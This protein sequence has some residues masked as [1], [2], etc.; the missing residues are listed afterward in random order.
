MDT[1]HQ[2]D[3]VDEATGKLTKGVYHINL[4]DEVTQWEVV[5]AVETISEHFLKPALEL[6]LECFPFVLHNF[7][8]DNGS[9][10]INGMVE[11]LL[12]ELN[13]AQTKSRARKSTDNGLVESKNGS[14]LR[15]EL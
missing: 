6:A 3:L 10:F 5:I 7:H 4:V 8:S 12:R 2:G 9:E 13:I 11:K 14:I 1:V 15:K